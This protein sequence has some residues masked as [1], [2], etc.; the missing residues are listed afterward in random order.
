MQDT[1]MGKKLHLTEYTGLYVATYTYINWMHVRYPQARLDQCIKY[2]HI[3][4][5]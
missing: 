5:I 2:Y 1:P 3:T 4:T